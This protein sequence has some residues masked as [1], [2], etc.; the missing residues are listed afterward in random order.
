LEFLGLE[1]EYSQ[2]ELE[3][4]LIGKLQAFLLELGGDFTFVG[5]FFR[6]FAQRQVR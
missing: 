3:E 5:R 2:S 4:A 1:D 6:R